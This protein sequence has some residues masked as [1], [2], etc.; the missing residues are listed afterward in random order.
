MSCGFTTDFANFLYKNSRNLFIQTIK[1]GISIELISN[2]LTWVENSSTED[3]KGSVCLYL[4]EQRV[5]FGKGTAD[6]YASWQTGFRKLAA[7]LGTQGCK[8]AELF[9]T[10][11]GPANLNRAAQI[12][13]QKSIFSKLGLLKKQFLLTQKL[14]RQILLFIRWESQLEGDYAKQEMAKTRKKE[15]TLSVLL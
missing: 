15:I 2:V 13:M 3:K 6:G 14:L 5:G 7:Y 10:I 4:K 1:P 12:T 9:T 8:K 11:W